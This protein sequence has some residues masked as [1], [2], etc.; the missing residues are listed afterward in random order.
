VLN[1]LVRVLG[2]FGIRRPVPTLLLL[3]VLLAAAVPGLLRVRVSADLSRLVAQRSEASRGLGLLLEG[4]AR[5][6]TVFGLLEL[7]DGAPPDPARLLDVGDSV[8]AALA[9]SPLVSHAR[10][11][12]SS[13][14]PKI[15]PLLVF[16]LADATTLDDVA[17]RLTTEAVE[18]RAK[19]LRELLSG[20]GSRELRDVALS[21]PMGLLES[22]REH[23]GRKLRHL[24][25]R[26]EGFIAPDGRALIVMIQPAQSEPGDMWEALNRDLAERGAA[27][28]AADPRA[29][30]MRLGFTG[31]PVHSFEIARMTKRDAALLSTVSF[32]AILLVYAVFYRSLTSLILVFTLLP[33]S[34]ILTLGVAGYVLGQVTPMAAGFLAV[35]FGTGVD[36]SIHLVSRYREARL[37]LPAPEAARESVRHVGPAVLLASGTSALALGAIAIVDRHAMGELGLLAGFGLLA[38]ALLLLPV[39]PA[40]FVLLGDRL[41]PDAGVGV[42]AAYGVSR[43]L[44]RRSAWVLAAAALGLLYLLSG[45][46]RLRY[47]ASLDGF[48]P[49]DL[50]PVQLDAAMRRH[51]Q[52]DAPGIAVLLT[53]KDEESLLRADD[54]WADV[55]DGLRAR[56]A[57]QSFDSLATLL[58]AQETARERRAAAR[59]RMD[60]PAA[61]ALMREALPRHGLRVEPFEPALARLDALAAGEN[62][63]PVRERHDPEWLS[64]IEEKHLSRVGGDW[65]TVTWIVA[66]G[67]AAA[68]AALLR[69]RPPPLPDGVQAWITGVPLVSAE[70][71]H[72]LSRMLPR[73]VLGAATLL[74]IVLALHYRNLR[75]AAVVWAPLLASLL[76]Y[77]GIHGSA[78]DAVDLSVLAALPLLLGVGIDDNVFVMDRYLEGGKPGRLDETLS[79]TGRAILVTTLTTVSSFGVMSLSSLPALSKFGFAVMS[80][81]LLEFVASVLLVPAMLARFVPGQDA[82]GGGGERPPSGPAGAERAHAG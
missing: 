60:I 36:P 11:R 17:G 47:E 4:F 2:E 6:P 8:A 24:G 79:G 46:G 31:A 32:F 25:E 41:K 67:D 82:P 49:P 43:W 53:A 42:S 22:F 77:V 57:V 33:L 81:L 50:A 72:E 64:W 59:E 18:H 14:I 70:A 3:G 28:L 7:P 45:A 35:L 5:R 73:L 58:A 74:G 16:D 29:T 38:N 23:A 62:P 15:D 69:E 12:P 39:L 65:R 55:L 54:A 61:T 9:Q 37:H 21:D 71:A 75:R 76:A 20:P 66:D 51:F 63:G 40:I 26:S 10:V 30:G 1:W 56:G 34:S 80:A 27:A 48:Q 13:A 68:T 44:Y 19:A 78:G 52:E